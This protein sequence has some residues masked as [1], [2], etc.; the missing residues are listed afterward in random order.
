MRGARIVSGN[1]RVIAPWPQTID[2]PSVTGYPVA[3]GLP[4]VV[5][6]IDR[7]DSPSSPGVATQYGGPWTVGA[8]TIGV[9]NRAFYAPDGLNGNVAWIDTRV[10]PTRAIASMFSPDYA[11]YQPQWIV[12]YLDALNYL[13]VRPQLSNHKIALYTVDAGVET[14][15]TGTFDPTMVDGVPSRIEVDFSVPRAL[16]V[17]IDGVFGIGANLTAPQA[18]KYLNLTR[19]G[20]GFT[21]ASSP[22]VA[23]NAASISQIEVYG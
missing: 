15:L 12:R 19:V 7:A 4:L 6:T 3:P 5:D 22:L 17:W 23:N 8:G 14:R 11:K 10:P 20:V 18:A 21:N 9:R 1:A 16:I 13:F 2:P